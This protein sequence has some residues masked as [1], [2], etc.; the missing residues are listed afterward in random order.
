MNNHK[1]KISVSAFFKRFPNDETAQKQFEQW[2]WGDTKRCP[3]CDSV[4]ISENRTQKM[5]FRCKDCR[6][7][8]SVRT[9]TVMANSN[10]GFQKWMYAVYVATVG[11][12]GTASTK[13]SSDIDSTQKL[14]W[15]LGHRIRK[16]W[17]QNAN[18]ME[19]IIEVDEAYFGG[20]EGN[21]HASKKSNAGRG[22]VGKTAVVAAKNRDDNSI[23]A[24]VVPKTTKRELQGFIEAN[25]DENAIVYTDDHKSYIGLPRK[26][27][28]VKHSVGEYVDGQAHINGVESFWALLKRGYHGTHHHMSA[29]HL[30]R[31]V[32]EFA[33]RHSIRK[34]D[35]INAMQIVAKGMIGKSMTYREL[36]A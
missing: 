9:N 13:L 27:G 5:P 6:K 33:S 12:K 21:K 15:F 18:M 4:R 8:F 23:K 26:H 19:G 29:K 24:R 25:V 31:Y 17:E 36:T 2:R 20:K 28:T 35:T 16:A 22:T 10:L 30:H 1:Q 14:A 32:D 11:I 7:K 3:Q 34:L